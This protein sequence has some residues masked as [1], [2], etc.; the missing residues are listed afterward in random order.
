MAYTALGDIWDQ[1][2]WKR[3]NTYL[4]MAFLSL[5]LHTY[6]QE[7]MKGW[8]K[9]NTEYWYDKKSIMKYFIQYW[10]MEQRLELEL[11]RD[12]T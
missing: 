7:Y 11:T 1:T 9:C 8:I 2:P 3:V 5:K 6:N 4:P 12:T 10:K